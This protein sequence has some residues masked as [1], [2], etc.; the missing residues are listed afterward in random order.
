MTKLK[1]F[2]FM[3][4]LIQKLRFSTQFIRSELGLHV[5]NAVDRNSNTVVK[6]KMYEDHQVSKRKLYWAP[7][8]I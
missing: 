1:P 7:V 2:V 8:T 6:L 5:Q 3:N 4:S